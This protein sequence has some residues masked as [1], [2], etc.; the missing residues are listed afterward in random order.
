MTMP[1][2]DYLPHFFISFLAISPAMAQQTD[3]GLAG[4]ARIA[5]AVQRLACY[6]RLA[7]VAPV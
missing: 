5:E 2:T 7:G 6:D 1:A 3:P 4:C